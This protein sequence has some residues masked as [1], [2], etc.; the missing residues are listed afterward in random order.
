MSHRREG[1]ILEALGV[2]DQAEVEQAAKGTLCT[3]EIVAEYGDDSLCSKLRQANKVGP[4]DLPVCLATTGGMVNKVIP[5]QL[6]L[7]HRDPDCMLVIEQNGHIVHAYPRAAP[8]RDCAVDWGPRTRPLA[9]GV[10]AE[11][12]AVA[13][14]ALD[15]A[16]SRSEEPCRRSCSGQR[17]SWHRSHRS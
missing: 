1:E 5:L 11:V 12:N 10:T 13:D 14:A 16:A 6:M 9:A 4:N 15:E 8:A 17:D 3:P 2:N 7:A